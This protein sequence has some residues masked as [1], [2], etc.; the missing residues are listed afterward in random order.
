VRTIGVLFA[1][2]AGATGVHVVNGKLNLVLTNP[3]HRVEGKEVPLTRGR[4]QIQSE[5][6]QVS[7][8]N[9]QIRPIQQIP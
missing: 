1:W 7:Y 4:I 3:R 9:L 5:G 6:A 2:L 8:R